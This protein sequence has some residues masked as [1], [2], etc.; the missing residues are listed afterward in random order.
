MELPELQVGYTQCVVGQRG[1]Y[2]FHKQSGM[3]PKQSGIS[4]SPQV[5]SQVPI[6]KVNSHKTHLAW[7]C[8]AGAFIELHFYVLVSFVRERHYSAGYQK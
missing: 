7:S 1:P 8:Q 4:C 5:E 2:K 6:N 3:L